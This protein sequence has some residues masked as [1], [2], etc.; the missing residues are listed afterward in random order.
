MAQVSWES[1]LWDSRRGQVRPQVQRQERLWGLEHTRKLNSGT[2]PFSEHPGV[3]PEVPSTTSLARA[4]AY[5][6]GEAPPPTRPLPLFERFPTNE[7]LSQVL[8]SPGP[9]DL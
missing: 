5:L 6:I 3:A 2:A 7:T 8:W 4:L 9:S 1:T